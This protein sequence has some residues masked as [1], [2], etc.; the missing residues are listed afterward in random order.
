LVERKWL[1]ENKMRWLRATPAAGAAWGG[2][3]GRRQA[4][5]F[6]PG[7]GVGHTLI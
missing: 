3:R 1:K 6:V 5:E 4:K 7:G 2:R